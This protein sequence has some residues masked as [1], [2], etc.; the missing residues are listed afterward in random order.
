MVGAGRAE[1][2]LSGFDRSLRRLS[3]RL[4]PHSRLIIVGKEEVRLAK[5]QR[6]CARWPGSWTASDFI[7]TGRVS[8]RALR[9]LHRRARLHDPSEHEGFCVPLVEA[10]AM[11][12]PIVG[13]A[14]TGHSG[15]GR[16][17]GTH[18]GR[19]AILTCWRN[20]INQLSRSVGRRGF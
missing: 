10:M 15:N 14:S 4:N 7:F 17:R 5:Y 16:E 1:Q 2:S 3:S 6:S 19:K 9:L 13:Y 18:L 12:I 11:K 20:R 8:D